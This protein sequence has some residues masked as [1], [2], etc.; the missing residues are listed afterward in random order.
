MTA[1]TIMVG[2]NL[3]DFMMT[4]TGYWTHATAMLAKPVTQK[5][6][7]PSQTYGSQNRSL[8]LRLVWTFKPSSLVAKKVPPQSNAR[9]QQPVYSPHVKMSPTSALLNSW[10][11][12]GAPSIK[13]STTAMHT[14][15]TKA[16]QAH[17]ACCLLPTVTPVAD[18]SPINNSFDLSA[19][20]QHRRTRERRPS[21]PRLQQILSVSEKMN[22]KAP[23]QNE[24][25]AIARPCLLWTR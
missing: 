8:V 2:I 13:S 21:G 15:I 14:T 1:D 5:S 24:K 3:D 22:T 16:R 25:A 18:S 12:L 7:N 4:L 6:R 11:L 9:R 23:I 20:V 10:T 19:G 17:R